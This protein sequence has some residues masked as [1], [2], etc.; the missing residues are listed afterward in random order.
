M[1]LWVN[2]QSLF[3]FPAAFAYL[4]KNAKINNLED[5]DIVNSK[6]T[7]TAEMSLKAMSILYFF[8]VSTMAVRYLCS[9]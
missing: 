7:Q 3:A 4:S 2:F 5:S 6:Q 1:S 9:Q 8:A